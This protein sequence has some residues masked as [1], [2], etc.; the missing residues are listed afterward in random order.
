MCEPQ[1]H[2]IL[3]N[4]IRLNTS[5]YVKVLSNKGMTTK[6]ANDQSV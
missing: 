5:E 3:K 1:E 2:V 6:T 4:L